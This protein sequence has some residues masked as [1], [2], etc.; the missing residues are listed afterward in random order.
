MCGFCGYTTK[1]EIIKNDDYLNKMISSIL[2]RGPN[3]TEN[4]IDNFVG[5]AHARLSI[6]DVKNGNQPMKKIINQKE[7]VICYNGELYNT[8]MLRNKLIRLGYT[9][10]TTCDT[11]VILTAYIEYKEKCLDYFNG[12][13]AFAIYDKFKNEI[14]LARDRLGIKPLFYTKTDNEIIFAS[15]I[16]AILKKD[17][18][19]KVLD[20]DGLTQMFILGPAHLPGKTYFKDILEIKPGYYAI[21]KDFNITLKKYWDLQTKPCVDTFEEA[22]ENVKFLVTDACK[23]QLVSDVGICSMLSGGLDSS[24]LTTIANKNID[25]LTTF[26]INYKDNDKDFTSNSYQLTK[27]S[28]FVKIMNDFLNINHKNVEIENENLFYLLKNSLVARDMPGMADIDSSMY[29][30]CKEIKNAGFKVCLSGECSDE[31]FGGYPWFYKEKLTSAEGFPWALSEN[32]R[33]NLLKSDISKDIDIYEYIKNI[34]SET[35][36]NVTNLDFD[37]KYQIQYR[38]I[39]YLTIKYFMMCL[40]ERTDRMSM[41]NSLEVRVPFA[42]HRIFEY[43]YN[44]PYTYKLGINKNGDIPTEK[45]IL[46]KAFINDLP[47]DIIS[48]KKSPFPKTYNKNYL[49]LCENEIS[50]ILNDKNS[51]ILDI[52]NKNYIDDLIKTKGETLKENLF[53]QLMTYPQ[54]LAY[55]IQIEYWLDLYDIDIDL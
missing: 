5:L 8:E 33:T 30:F 25:N 12:I 48:R 37:S 54:T 27:D 10:N 21:I 4:Y 24:I 3:H 20:K 47:K 44:L 35:L 39:N 14:F 15:E 55:L 9:F 23:K 26:S 42:D 1:D 13:F 31:I 32:L 34:K 36:K 49:K 2:Y 19:K 11:E 17:G 22:T 40:V 16:K 7:Y 50:R 43:A 45:Y 46:K 41:S 52:V 51:K 53:G 28:D 38:N 29:A 6:I 18:I